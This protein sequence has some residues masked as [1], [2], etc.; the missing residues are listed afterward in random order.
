MTKKHIIISII[1]ILITAVCMP[2]YADRRTE[3]IELFLLLDKSKSMVEEISDV[4]SYVNSYFLEDFLIP[5]DRFVLIE[6]YGKNEVVYDRM[7]TAGGLPGME[8]RIAGIRADGRF[9]DIGRALDRLKQTVNETESRYERQYFI[10]LTDGKQEAPEDSP[11]YSPDGS[12]NHAFLENTKTIQRRGWKIMIIGI[13]DNTVVEDLADELLTTSKTVESSDR[14]AD[15]LD[16]EEIIGRVTAEAFSMDGG[17][18]RIRL[19]SEGYSGERAVI[20]KQ[21]L[22]QQPGG[23]YEILAA[24]TE[25]IIAPDEEKEFEIETETAGVPAGSGTV[26]F[27]FSGDT[28][29]I[30]AAFDDVV[31][32]GEISPDDSKNTGSSGK[33]E[34]E[35]VNKT[36]NWLII[37]I[38]VIAAA[39][40]TAVILI[41]N[42]VM[43]K[44]EDEESERNR[45]KISDDN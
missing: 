13:G 24:E 10:L 22:F 41:R 1:S 33:K 27:K 8:D 38:A 20:I 19:R 37:V 23:N 29:F 43:H 21:I 32:I 36:F 25:L 44:D 16:S 12:F 17:R 28:P 31:V 11:Y 15:V 30:P 3:N 5:G 39:A 2:L 35:S 26:L 34:A 4:T 6:F 18:I 9:T 45:K 7:I 14:I 40:V 42:S